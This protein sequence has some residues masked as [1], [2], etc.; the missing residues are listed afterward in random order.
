MAHNLNAHPTQ[1]LARRMWQTFEPYHA[2]IYFAPEARQAY[3]DAGL[4][5][6][7]MGY[8]ASRA[9]PMGP[10]PA[11]VVTATFYN[12]HQRMVA[13]A[14]PDAWRFSSPEQI[15]SARFRSADAALRRLLGQ[16]ISSSSLADA[17]ALAHTAI[18]ACDVAGRPLFAAHY[19]LPWP[20][21]PHLALWHAATLL[22]EYRGDGHVVALLA[23]GLDGCEAHVTQAAVGRAPRETLQPNRGWTD[24]EWTAAEERLRKRGWLDASGLVTETGRQGRQAIEDR[25]DALASPPWDHLGLEHTTRLSELM[26]PL[27]DTIM[28]KAGIPVPNPLGLSWP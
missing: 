3:A 26:W 21:E 8:F 16:E 28:R 20:D 6:Y 1:A 9:A 7:W 17:H 22:R 13:R 27:S 5:G 24:E 4:K 19:S 10:V 14:I 25:T 23:E 11:D 2:M 15:L 12:F 18:Q